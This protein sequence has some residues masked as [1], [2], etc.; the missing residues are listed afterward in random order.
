MD[1]FGRER[2]KEL[3]EEPEG[4][5]VSLYL[6]TGRSSAEADADRLRFR[7][8]LDRARELLSAEGGDGSRADELLGELEPLTRDADFW[9]YQADGLAVFVARGFQRMYRVPT[10]LPELVVVGPTFHTRPLLEYLQAPDRYWVLGVGRNGVRLWQ[11]TAGGLAPMD[12]SGLPRSLLD[13]LGFEYEKDVEIVHRRK[14]GPSRGERGRGGHQPTFHGHGVGKDDDEPELKKFFRKV[15]RGVR[16]LLEDEI[17]PVVLAAVQEYHPLYRGVSELNNL[18]E[19]GIHASVTTVAEWPLE[20]LHEEAWP[21]ARSAALAR[22]DEALEL[23]EKAYGQGKGEMDLANLGRLAVAG[24]L[25][26]LLTERGRRIWGTI[27]RNTGK[28][29][30]LQDGGDDPGDQAVDLLDELAEMTV[31]RGGR[32]LVL[33]AERMPTETGAAGVLR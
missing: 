27:D 7:A 10:D 12:L 29:E 11:G 2:L 15:D 14:A 13:A 28:L 26:L 22:V 1:Y 8:A 21:I 3:L 25:R 9:R 16:E 24:R 19:E 33:S 6:P 31:L 18:V 5:A 17:G 32:A 30:I 4:P 20:R 23:W